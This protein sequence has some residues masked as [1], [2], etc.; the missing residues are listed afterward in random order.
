MI[1]PAQP[2]ST[3]DAPEHDFKNLIYHLNAIDNKIN[4]KAYKSLCPVQI[5][6]VHTYGLF[7][8]GNL[9]DDV[10][11]ER[12]ARQVLGAQWLDKIQE[13]PHLSKVG[14]AKP[15]VTINVLGRTKHNLRLRLGGL[16]IRFKFRPLVVQG[17][18]TPVNISGPSMARNGMDQIHSKGCLMIRGKKVPLFSPRDLPEYT[19]QVSNKIQA[20]QHDLQEG[21]P[22]YIARDYAIPPNTA[23]YINVRI[24]V[25]EKR[26]CNF[27]EGVLESGATFVHNTDLH[28]TVRAAVTLKDNGQVITSVLNT[29]PDYVTIKGDTYFGQ[30]YP[31]W[32][33]FQHGIAQIQPP[34]VI[35]DRQ[36]LMENFKLNHAPWL[37]DKP[38]EIERALALLQEFSDIISTADEYGKTDLIEHEIRVP[39]V[40][41]IRTKNRPINPVMEAD[42]RQQMDKWLTQDVVEHSQSPWSFGLLAVPKK[43]GKTRWCVDYRRLNDITLKDSFPLPNMEDNLARLAHSKVFSGIDGTGAYHVVSIK[44]EHRELT[45]FSTPWGL[46]QFKQMPFGLC[47]APATYSRLVQRVLA[48][49]PTSVAL[50]YLD[51]TC[52]HTK[53]LDEHY[54]VLRRIFDAHRKAGLMIQPEKCQLFQESIEYLGHIISA[55]GTKPVPKYVELVAQWPIPTT[56]RELRTFLGKVAYY[57]KFIPEFAHLAGPLYQY[58]KKED[59]TSTPPI[60]PGSLDQSVSTMNGSSDVKSGYARIGA[61]VRASR[62]V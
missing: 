13:L 32:D 38:A 59:E 47:N 44:P 57:R 34:A 9:V 37:K 35:K 31:R 33:Q 28:P 30:I 18:N 3:N 58:L 5:D 41:P 10:I 21:Y 46:Y 11:S 23:M 6:D 14:T 19:P 17:L 45:A 22:T 56:L 15:G 40:T 51:D 4:K 61:L 12:F 16:N 39:D 36:W 7:D 42:L 52:V 62:K 49:I 53:T 55:E 24:P 25:A 20:L 1:S 48:D 2:T 8:S 26:Q 50:P 60:A 54:E 43:N 27:S 29:T